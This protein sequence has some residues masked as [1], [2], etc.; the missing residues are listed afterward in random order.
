[1]TDLSVSIKIYTIP[2]E[3]QKE[4]CDTN[5]D[6]HD[7]TN[8]HSFYVHNEMTGCSTAST[9]IFSI[10][11]NTTFYELREMIEYKKDHHTQTGC[12]MLRR[13]TL[14][15]EIMYVAMNCSNP[16]QYGNN[17]RMKYCFGMLPRSRRLNENEFINDANAIIN[18]TMMP[19][20]IN[21]DIEDQPIVEILGCDKPKLE[22]LVIPM[23]QIR[24]EDGI[25]T[26]KHLV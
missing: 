1:M 20:T 22:L 7:K 18:D 9:T 14:H 17:E 15:S 24:P 12:T 5:N 8:S 16:F 21:T 6:I 10:S 4:E 13:T 26:R 25:V 3:Y 2:L 11:T 23:S 19:I